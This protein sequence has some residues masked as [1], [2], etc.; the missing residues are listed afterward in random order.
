MRAT[1]T[2]FPERNK[3]LSRKAGLWYWWAVTARSVMQRAINNA[4]ILNLPNCP[5][6]ALLWW[7]HLQNIPR[8]LC[9]LHNSCS[10]ICQHRCDSNTNILLP[11]SLNP[12]L[13]GTEMGCGYIKSINSQ[14]SAATRESQ[15]HDR[16]PAQGVVIQQGQTDE[17]G[18]PKFKSL[19]DKC[20]A[21]GRGLSLS[22]KTPDTASRINK[23]LKSTW[24]ATM[25]TF[26]YIHF[27]TFYEVFADLRTHWES[28]SLSD[29]ICSFITGIFFTDLRM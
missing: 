27:I 13:Q 23:I 3:N 19:S 26:T 16:N 20:L 7:A 24:K 5:P 4:N 6:W 17:F 2:K 14:K 25:E 28:S 1:Y 12:T 18:R 10:S 9:A 11:I 29:N 15:E 21:L 8:D 22:Q